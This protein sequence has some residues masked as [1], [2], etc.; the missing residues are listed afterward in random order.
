MIL[1]NPARV[2]ISSIYVYVCVSV[3]IH[4]NKNLGY[5]YLVAQIFGRRTGI[6]GII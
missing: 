4:I 1:V 3:Y 2:C 5:G 6:S